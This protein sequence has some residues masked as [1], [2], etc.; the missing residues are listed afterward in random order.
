MHLN[1]IGIFIL[2]IRMNNAPPHSIPKNDIGL[3]ENYFP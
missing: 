3:E 2:S 1:G